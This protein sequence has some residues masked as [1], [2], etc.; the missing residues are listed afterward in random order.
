MF[1]TLRLCRIIFVFCG[2]IYPFA[3]TGIAQVLMPDQANGSLVRNAEG[4]A[5]GSS[6]IGQLFSSTRYFNGRVSSI[7]YDASASGSNN[8]GP[9]NEVMLQRVQSDI[10]EFLQANP[11]AHQSEIPGDLLTN[12]GS[13]LDPH[14]SPQAARIQVPRIARER[15]MD[16]ARLYELINARIEPPLWGIFG[17]ARVE[18]LALNLALD[19]LH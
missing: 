16:P 5:I 9:S 7:D 8:Y 2:L 3:M 15:D 14:V 12:S 11:V 1:G 6:L 4:V 18:V 17:E 13:G 10:S 19:Q